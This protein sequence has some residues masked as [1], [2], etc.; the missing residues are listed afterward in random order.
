MP[1]NKAKY[2]CCNAAA[3]KHILFMDKLLNGACIDRQLLLERCRMDPPPPPGPPALPQSLAG[4]TF[5]VSDTVDVAGSVTGCGVAAADE[6]A[7]QAST[8]APIVQSL[9]DA[10]ATLVGK[11][12]V[13]VLS[14]CDWLSL[15][16]QQVLVAAQL[17]EGLRT[18]RV[19][20]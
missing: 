13:Q 14:L 8:S 9:L 10:G 20:F 4:L 5:V 15:G 3:S 17:H 1:C 16:Q 18:R 19:M 2:F 12:A 11:T 7:E 6:D